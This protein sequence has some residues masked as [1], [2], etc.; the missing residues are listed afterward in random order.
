[1]QRAEE[2]RAAISRFYHAADIFMPPATP[3]GYP[4]L[5]LLR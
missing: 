3:L 4:P 2:R 1:M 5:A